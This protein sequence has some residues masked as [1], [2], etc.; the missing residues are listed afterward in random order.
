MYF[1]CKYP[2]YRFRWAEQEKE[3]GDLFFMGFLMAQN[4]TEPWDVDADLYQLQKES[5]DRLK[6]QLKRKRAGL[7]P[8]RIRNIKLKYK[9][10]FQYD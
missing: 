7:P 10:R 8:S 9:P 5:N 6:E 1:H 3:N 4:P 2:Y